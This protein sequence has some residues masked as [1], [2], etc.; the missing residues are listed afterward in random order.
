MVIHILPIGVHTD[1]VLVGLK[2]STR[3][4][5]VYLLHSPNDRKPGG[6]KGLTKAKQL[7]KDLESHFGPIE[8][9]EINAFEVSNIYLK[10]REIVEKEV[11]ESGIPLIADNFAVGI[12]GGTNPMACGAVIG[13][14][15]A[16][17]SAYYVRDKRF[18]PDRE[19]YVEY[20]DLPSRS[21]M[22]YVKDL[23]LEILKKLS[24]GSYEDY[25]GNVLPGMMR[26]IILVDDIGKSPNTINSAIKVLKDKGL[27]KQYDEDMVRKIKVDRFGHSENVDEMKKFVRYEITSSGR[28]QILMGT[29]LTTDEIRE[30]I[31]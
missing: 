17:V 23:Q 21:M 22:V 25:Q 1:H 20:L 16:G 26:R 8:L 27:V 9:V 10:I 30:N 4:D 15:L 6:F 31:E 24:E 29:T 18:E 19:T 14:G 28:Y 2:E 13:A 12:T 7:K 11:K 5:K 3:I